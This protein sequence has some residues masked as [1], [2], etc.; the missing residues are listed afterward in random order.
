MTFSDLY[1]GYIVP[2]STLLPIGA[3]VIYY[4][5][6]GKA[7]HTLIIYLGIALLINIAGIIMAAHNKNNLPLLHLYTAFELVAVVWYYKWAFSVPLVNKWSRVI[8][9]VYPILCVI[10]F[11]FFQSIYK[12]N[13][14]TRPL[15]AIIIIAFSGIYLSNQHRLSHKELTASAGRW[16]A[17]GFLL[18]FCSSLFQFI[19]S[20][21]VSK[22]AS[23]DVKLLI[24]NI[25]DTFVM[26]M[27]IIFFI[28]IQR[29]RSER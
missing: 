9:I 29:E 10:N 25:H 19:F 8:M 23:R 5:K 27:Y 21:V 17:S 24:W 26:I 13:T 12:F 2:G 15:E 3:G 18:Y 6:L 1:S 22:H 4:K 16:V 20:N 14:Y 7:I 28:G 11:I